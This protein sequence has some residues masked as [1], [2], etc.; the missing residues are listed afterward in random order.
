MVNRIYSAPKYYS[1]FL[2]CHTHGWINLAPYAWDKLK[3]R[4]EFVLLSKEQAV[5]VSVQQHNG[6]IRVSVASEK[7][8]RPKDVVELDT[9]L[10][11][12]L[13]LGQDTTELMT[14]ALKMIKPYHLLIKKGA[15]RLLRGASLW[16]DAAKTLFTTNC[17]WALTQKMCEKAC[18]AKYSIPSP[19]GKYPFPPPSSLANEHVEILRKNIPIGYRADYLRSLACVFS[20]DPYLGNIE[21]PGHTYEEAYQR[22]SELKGFGPYARTHLMLLIGHFE[23]IPVD[24]EVTS[25][26]RKIYQ[27]RDVERFVNKQYSP[28]GKYKWWGLKLEKMLLRQNWLGD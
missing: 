4:L 20:E 10:A 8:I 21:I 14:V 15:G 16:E 2:T 17:S 3:N 13:D 27:C 26:I 5:D 23:K 12:I 6:S 9:V 19:K 1:L 7:A 11:R 25:F 28:W 18:S 24:S 22:I